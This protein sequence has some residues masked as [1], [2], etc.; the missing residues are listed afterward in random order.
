[1][2]VLISDLSDKI[3]IKTKNV[4][5]GKERHFIMGKGQFIRKERKFETCMHKNIKIQQ[6]STKS[7]VGQGR[8]HKGH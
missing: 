4:A 6:H 1:M 8:K 3:D 2:A 7:P 5:R